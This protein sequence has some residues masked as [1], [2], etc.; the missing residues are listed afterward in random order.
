MRKF[1]PTSEV[2]LVGENSHAKYYRVGQH[3]HVISTVCSIGCRLNC[4]TC[5]SNRQDCEH[6]DAVERYMGEK[7]AEAA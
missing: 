3:V 5:S 4:M 7:I 6:V 2:Q 1:I